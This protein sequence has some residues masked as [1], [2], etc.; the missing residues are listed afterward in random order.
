[1]QEG[2]DEA[3]IQAPASNSARE[4]SAA[5]NARNVKSR[6]E[7]SRE[8]SI[9]VSSRTEDLVPSRKRGSEE[10]GPPDDPSLTE[11]DESLM[12]ISEKAVALVSL[13]VAPSNFKVAE[14][15]CRNRFGEAAVSMG[16]ERC[17]VVD[18]ATGWNMS[19][20]EQMKEFE[21]RV[22]DEEPVLLIGFHCVA[23]SA[24]CWADAGHRQ[25]E[26]GQ[27]QEP[28]RTLRH[29]LQVLLQHVKDTANCR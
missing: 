17:L 19:D 5:S 12:V 16:F 1:M 24:L 9:G 14:L 26:R 27:L 6:V 22:R 15:F 29:T 21:Q 28:R 23:H 3:M 2:P 4:A 10:V 11:A 20:E 18:C 7:V 8:D 25:T 13:G